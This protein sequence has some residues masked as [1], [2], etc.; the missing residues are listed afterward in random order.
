M[1]QWE[2]KNRDRSDLRVYLE[3]APGRP[4]GSWEK[5]VGQ[6]SDFSF[7]FSTPLGKH[8]FPAWGPPGSTDHAQGGSGQRGPHT[9]TCC[10]KVM[11]TPPTLRNPWRNIQ[12][13]D[14]QSAQTP[15]QPGFAF[16]ELQESEEI[17]MGPPWDPSGNP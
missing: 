16:M 8:D 11:H 7:T 10:K 12:D 5:W 6:K 4:R 2:L 1:L 17:P 9:T 3:R 13:P 15:L 14:L